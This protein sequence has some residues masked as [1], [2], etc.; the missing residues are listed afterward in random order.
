ML[1]MR[2]PYK[3]GVTCKVHR[4]LF[5]YNSTVEEIL[6]GMAEFCGAAHHDVELIRPPRQLHARV[7]DD[8]AVELYRWEVLRHLLALLQYSTGVVLDIPRSCSRCLSTE[9]VHAA[10]HSAWQHPP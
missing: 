2:L 6:Q 9:K 1:V 3:L 7:V 4:E 10:L 5:S 8:H